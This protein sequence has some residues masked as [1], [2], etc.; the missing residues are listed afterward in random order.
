MKK[1]FLSFLGLFLVAAAHAARPVTIDVLPSGGDDT[2]LLRQALAQAAACKGP[3]VLR[4][5]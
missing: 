5:R 1:V 3:V 2:P 4:L